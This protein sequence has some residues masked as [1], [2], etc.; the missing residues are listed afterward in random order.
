M[1]DICEGGMMSRG[2]MGMRYLSTETVVVIHVVS[3]GV[4]TPVS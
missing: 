3:P 2:E 4:E 1:I